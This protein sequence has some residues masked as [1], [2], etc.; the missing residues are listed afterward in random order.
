MYGGPN[1]HRHLDQRIFI[2][3]RLPFSLPSAVAQCHLVKGSIS[4]AHKISR[5]VLYSVDLSC[6][7]GDD[8]VADLL[9]VIYLLSMLLSLLFPISQNRHIDDRRYLPKLVISA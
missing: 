3:S 6:R 4:N 2:K 8:A 1:A 9:I 5:S 7:R